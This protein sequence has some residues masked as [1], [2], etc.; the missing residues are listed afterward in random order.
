MRLLFL[1]IGLIWTAVAVLGFLVWQQAADAALQNG[2]APQILDVLPMVLIPGT[3]AAFS[4]AR[5]LRRERNHAADGASL[6]E[7]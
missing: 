1:G 3:L 6:P 7:D 5:L 4:L 2:T